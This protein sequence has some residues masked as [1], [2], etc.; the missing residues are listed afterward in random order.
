MTISLN[1]RSTRLEKSLVKK[2]EPIIGSSVGVGQPATR[3]THSSGK[4]YTTI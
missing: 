3:P 2:D 1:G 4:A